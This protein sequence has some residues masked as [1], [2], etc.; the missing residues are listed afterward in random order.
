MNYLKTRKNDLTPFE[1]FNQLFDW[2]GFGRPS[3]GGTALVPAMDVSENDDHLTITMELPGLTKEELDVTLENGVLSVSGEK[4]LERKTDEEHYHAV[5]R[6]TGSFRR[7]VSLP[8]DI[9]ADKA[10]A[11][12]EN[13]VLT[14]TVPKSEQVK[15]KRLSVK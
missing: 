15:P 4:K 2:M 7:S 12:F 10:D 9:D 5:E 13:G 11:S 6:R 1:G 3:N 14:I 8:S